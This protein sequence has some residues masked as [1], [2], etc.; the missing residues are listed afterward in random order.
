MFTAISLLKAL[1]RQQ[2]PALH[3]VA[4][5]NLL[6]LAVQP[7][8]VSLT[9]CLPSCSVP[10]PQACNAQIRVVRTSDGATLD[11]AVVTGTWYSVLT[12]ASWP[13]PASAA[14]GAT[15]VTGVAST[16][17]KTLPGKRG[18]G[19]W[20]VVSSIQLPGYFVD[21]SLSLPLQTSTVKW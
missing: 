1:P 6:W 18:N 16:T 5:E 19:C 21:P 15:G 10:L 20:F 7:K 13:Y 12:R 11:S 4:D 9:S 17:S 2:L 14:T 8:L 3:A